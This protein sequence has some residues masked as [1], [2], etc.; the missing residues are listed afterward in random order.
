MS[1]LTPSAILVLLIVAAPVSAQVCAGY[2]MP[3]GSLGFSA[4][5]THETVRDAEAYAA[6]ARWRTRDWLAVEGSV[7]VSEYVGSRQLRGSA[8]VVF[9]LPLKRFSM[10]ALAGVEHRSVEFDVTIRN[11]TGQMVGVASIAD[12]DWVFPVGFALGYSQPITKQASLFA[13]TQPHFMIWQTGIDVTKAFGI[14]A[15][16][17]DGV[18][19]KNEPSLRTGLGVRLN[20]IMIGI[21]NVLTS[22]EEA[23]AFGLRLSYLTR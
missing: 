15:T 23:S 5:A 6:S 7:G 13:Y 22:A 1:R 18:V 17:M 10:C 14:G 16:F 11:N 8:G 19:W 20:R 2:P 4:L 3:A 21:E 12:Q 9:E